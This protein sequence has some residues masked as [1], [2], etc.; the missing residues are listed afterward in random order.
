[1]SRYEPYG[2]RRQGRKKVS[3]GELLVYGV[4][5][6]SILVL[7]IGLLLGINAR[8]K[9]MSSALEQ[10]SEM[11]V[12]KAS[13]VSSAASNSDGAR[14]AGSLGNDEAD[15]VIDYVS[16]CG[17]AEVD[18]PKEREL[19]EIL[20]RLEGLA[21][22]N[23]MIAEICQDSS[24]Y[25]EKMLEALANNPEMADFVVHFPK[26]G[27]K[28]AGGLTDKEKEQQYP[29]F[30]Q[31]DPRWGYLAYGDSSNVGLAGCG[32]TSLSMVLYYLT[33]DESLTPGKIAEYSMKN[34]YYMYGTGTKWALLE[35]VPALYGITVEQPKA[36]EQDMKAALDRGKLIICSVGAG[37]FTVAGHFIVVYG[38]DENGFQVNDPNCVARSRKQWTYAELKKQIKHIW[39]FEKP[40]NI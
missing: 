15:Y 16:L 21:E 11:Q 26:S 10:L 5:P 9:E 17:L 13:R 40:K 34:G 12:N 20:A 29:L 30:L 1:M 3:L 2:K 38:Y 25:P 24:A 39:V 22:E 31:W 19:P 35:D 23:E 18:K 37:D 6:W 4:L 27:G 28:A 14:D 36:D 8:L 32:P 33:G 7:N